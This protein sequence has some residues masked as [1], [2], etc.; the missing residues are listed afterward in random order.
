MS[1][2]PDFRLVNDSFL[3][4]ALVSRVLATAGKAVDA[5]TAHVMVHTIEI[6]IEPDD[7]NGVDQDSGKL[8]H[9]VVPPPKDSEC[10]A[11]MAT[12]LFRRAVLG[13]SFVRE[14]QEGGDRMISSICKHC[15]AAIVADEKYA[16]LIQKVADA[17]QAVA[18]PTQVPA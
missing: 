15:I 7:E 9:L 12:E 13:W 16:G 5:R 18:T 17:Y 11:Q 2:K 1:K 14:V 10:P 8:M 4:D 6:E 3:A